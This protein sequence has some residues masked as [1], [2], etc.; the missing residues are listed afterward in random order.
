MEVADIP[1]AVAEAAAP[2][3]KEGPLPFNYVANQDEGD[4]ESWTLLGY[5]LATTCLTCCTRAPSRRWW[6][7]SRCATPPRGSGSAPVRRLRTSERA[8]SDI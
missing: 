5:S 2:A 7:R 6:K 8:C 4:G 3:V 1:E